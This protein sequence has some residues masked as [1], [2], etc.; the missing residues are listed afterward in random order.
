MSWSVKPGDRVQQFD[1]I[2]EVQSDKASVEVRTVQYGCQKPFKANANLLDV[3][4]RSPL[5]S[6]EPS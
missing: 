6:M 4:T 5:A 3:S 1:N 2:C